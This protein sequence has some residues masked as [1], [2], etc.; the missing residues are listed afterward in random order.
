MNSTSYAK[1]PPPCRRSRC[2]SSA[3]SSTGSCRHWPP[4]HRPPPGAIPTPIR[5]WGFGTITPMRWTRS[6]PTLTAS[7]GK[8]NGGNLTFE[9]NPA[10]HRHPVRD[11][12]GEEPHRCRQ[13]ED[14]PPVVRPLHVFDRL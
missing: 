2:V 12:Q 5:S 8:E 7:G 6:L 1:P 14:L 11:R 13:R 4:K 9:Q 3:M 10:R